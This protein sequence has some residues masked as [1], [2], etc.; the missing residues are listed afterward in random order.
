MGV[1]KTQRA[2]AGQRDIRVEIVKYTTVKNNINEDVKNVA[3]VGFFYAR[4]ED[5]SGSET[6]DGKVMH[7]INRIYTV[8][9]NTEVH[10]K[11]EHM[12]V[13]DGPREYRIYYVQ[14]VGR[15]EQLKLKCTNRE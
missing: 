3:S 14:E 5:L 12:V 1:D 7:I 8:P 10:A 6:T 2:F 4:V 15:K 13:K 11:G 9:Y